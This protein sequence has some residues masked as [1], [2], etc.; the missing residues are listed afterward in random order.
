ML[1]TE[2]P[3]TLPRGYVDKE[4]NLHREGVMRLATAYDEIAPMKDPRV[5]AN[6]GYLV[7]ILLSRVITKMGDLEYI[8]P[9]AIEGLFAGDLAYLQDLYQ[10]IN[11]DG[12]N[13]FVASYDDDG[14]FGWAEQITWIDEYLV[15]AIPEANGSVFLLGSF[16]NSMVLDQGGPDETTLQGPG[17]EDAYA[18]RF[19]A[20]GA[21]DW[22]ISVAYGAVD[23]TA[24]FDPLTDGSI[25]DWQRRTDA[26]LVGA[27]LAARRG[28]RVGG[29]LWYRDPRKVW[30][31]S[32]RRRGDDLRQH[33]GA[34][35]WSSRD[36]H[37]SSRLHVTV[38]WLGIP[39][40]Q[41]W[42]GTVERGGAPQSRRG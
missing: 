9:K 8:N 14:T 22:A 42:H 35:T 2:F 10:R 12:H 40:R 15:A 18:A 16:E 5:Q 13:R 33:R 26:A 23:W 34:G 27:S 25:E 29:R 41:I 20:S 19:S 32:S 37:G 30:R 3:F 31:L 21:F 38:P 4:G 17:G 11:E 1:Q 36:E 28:V 6:P 24:R 39:H 7:I